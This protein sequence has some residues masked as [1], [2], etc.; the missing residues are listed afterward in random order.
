[1]RPLPKESQSAQHV[2]GPC[3]YF[4]LVPPDG[5]VEDAL[6]L[7]LGCTRLFQRLYTVLSVVLQVSH[8]RLDWVGGADAAEAA[9]GEVVVQDKDLFWIVEAFDI[10]T[11]L[12][13]VGTSENREKCH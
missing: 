13:V 5:G 10:L 1:M 12:G 6:A 2:R 8:G 11:G 7:V 3:Y 9:E 4:V